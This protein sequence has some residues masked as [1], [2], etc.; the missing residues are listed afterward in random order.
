MALP[1]ASCIRAQ[2]DTHSFGLW[3]HS[4]QVEEEDGVKFTGFN[5]K[6]E[7]ETG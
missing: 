4:A 7:R 1:H 3:D 5:L 2:S 6:E